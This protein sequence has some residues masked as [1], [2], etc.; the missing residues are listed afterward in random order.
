MSD[1]IE[2]TIKN[3]AKVTSSPFKVRAKLSSTVQDLKEILCREYDGQPDTQSQTVGHSAPLNLQAQQAHLLKYLRC[4]AAH[5]RWQGSQGWQ[6]AGER[7]HSPSKSP[8][9]F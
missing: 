8:R 3:P 4:T 6:R 2:F 7:L 9:F 1:L 5:I